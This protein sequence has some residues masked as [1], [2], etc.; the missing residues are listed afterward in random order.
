M[1]IGFQGIG[2]L[3]LYVFSVIVS[4]AAVAATDVGRVS[5]SPRGLLL[6]SFSGYAAA[7]TDAKHIPGASPR[8]P[9]LSLDQPR[10]QFI[11]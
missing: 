10:K 8:Y 9:N 5:D 3:A 11:D 2:A 4:Y 1:V 6:I 7:S